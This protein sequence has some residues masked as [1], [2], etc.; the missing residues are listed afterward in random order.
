MTLLRE[1]RGSTVIV[2]R[3]SGKCATFFVSPH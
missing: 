2:Q 3:A 1:D